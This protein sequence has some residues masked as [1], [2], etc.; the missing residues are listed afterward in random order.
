MSTLKGMISAIERLRD[1]DNDD[2]DLT[3]RIADQLASDMRAA[4]DKF[5]QDMNIAIEGAVA[6]MKTALVTGR[7]NRSIDFTGIIGFDAGPV[8]GKDEPK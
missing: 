1:R 5:N 4:L 7:D 3:A 2:T 6:E 8:D